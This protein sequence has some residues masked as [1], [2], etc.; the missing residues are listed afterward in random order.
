MNET[1]ALVAAGQPSLGITQSAYDKVTDPIKF[2]EWMGNLIRQSGTFGT[3]DGPG[4]VAQGQLIAMQCL[5]EKLPPLEFARTYHMIEGKQVMR[6]DAMLAKFQ[7][8]GGKVRWHKM[9]DKE[10]SATFTSG[11]NS[12]DFSLTMEE[13]VKSG[14]AIGSGN[15]LKANYKK[16]PKAM[17]RA[18]LV[19]DAVRTLKPE[20]IFGYYTPEEVEDMN[21]QPVRTETQ[22]ASTGKVWTPADALNQRVDLRLDAKF[23]NSADV[24]NSYLVGKGIL[25]EGQSYRDLRGQQ[26]N[27]VLESADDILA[28]ATAPVVEIVEEAK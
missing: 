25:K 5:V 7:M 17:L 22:T 8:S 2:A 13:L 14:V 9:T 1:N 16:F 11:E 15:Q 23:G 26:A 27:T 19:S 10:V 4:G 18:R 28:N 6:S 21:P 12:L 20:I 24:V 3:A